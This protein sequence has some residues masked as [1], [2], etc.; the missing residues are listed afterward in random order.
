MKYTVPPD[1][2]NAAAYVVPYGMPNT[3][4]LFGAIGKLAVVAVTVEA[5]PNA[6]KAIAVP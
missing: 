4:M 5:V 2:P 1:V 6:M 3:S